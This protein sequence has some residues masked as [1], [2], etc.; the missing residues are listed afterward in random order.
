MPNAAIRRGAAAVAND[1]PKRPFFRALPWAIGGAFM[2]ASMAIGSV[3]ALGILSGPISFVGEWL[4]TGADKGF[5]RKQ[6]ATYYRV[7]IAK[8]LG[9]RPEQVDVHA[10]KKAAEL[11]PEIARLYNEP[12]RAQGEE[13]KGSLAMS[14]AMSAAGAVGLGG[15]AKAAETGSTVLKVAHKGA[16]VAKFGAGFIGGGLLSGILAKDQPEAQEI[17]EG[18]EQTLAS[19][20]QNGVDRRSV[21]NPHL[22]MSVRVTQDP[23]LMKE[24]KSKFKKGIHQMNPEEVTKALQE[25]PKLQLLAN[26]AQSEAAA[27]ANGDLN[28][29]ELA[30]MA[31]N[32]RGG[33]ASQVRG[34][35]SVATANDNTA[36]ANNN[37]MVA[38]EMARREAAAAA[39]GPRGQG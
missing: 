37:G 32:L 21:V 18:L 8:Q 2:A 34:P 4:R 22:I 12:K 24:I 7:Q 33:F 6:R 31:P 27:I 29:R 10:F 35:Q 13:L 1:L 19:A 30:A 26:A 15:L 3:P 39:V 14:A 5:E 36:S 38:R 23:V 11:N 28:V 20:D 16:Q 9:I 25:M 17:I